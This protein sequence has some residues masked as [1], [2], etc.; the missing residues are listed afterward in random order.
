VIF[1]VNGYYRELGF[2]F[3]YAGITRRQLRLAFLARNGESSIRLTYIMGQLLNPVSRREYDLMRYGDLYLDRDIQEWF[4]R[5]ALDE[6]RQ[7]T[8]EGHSPRSTVD[9]VLQEWGLDGDTPEEPGMDSV[10]EVGQDP[11]DPTD[12]GLP[13]PWTWSYYLWSSRSTDTDKLGRW[14]GKLIHELHSCGKRIRFCVGFS[15]RKRKARWATGVIGRHIVIFLR[16][17]VE[18]TDELAALAVDAV[19]REHTDEAE[20]GATR[21]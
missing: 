15:S 11:E 18:P 19:L 6:V 12:E 14:Q 3:P 7:R 20:K 17:D 1:D 13:V 2:T 9:E 4:R 21:G 8:P 5:K 10:G 16:E